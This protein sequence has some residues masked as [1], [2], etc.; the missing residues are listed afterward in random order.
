MKQDVQAFFDRITVARPAIIEHVYESGREND[1]V[2]DSIPC[3][4]CGRGD[5]KYS[6]AGNYNGHVS[7][8]CTTEGCARW[9]E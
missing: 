6:Y 5:L 9:L 1:Y 2:V 4:I 7:A 8:T 3:P